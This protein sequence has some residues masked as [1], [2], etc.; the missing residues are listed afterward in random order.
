METHDKLKLGLKLLLLFM[1]TALIAA[2]I[3]FLG[4]SNIGK[5]NQVVA[6]M[7]ANNLV[8]ITFISEANT[9]VINHNRRVCIYVLLSERSEKAFFKKKMMESEENVKTAIN[10]FRGSKLSD[11]ERLLLTKFDRIWPV[12]LENVKKTLALSEAGKDR[13]AESLA[14]GE[15]RLKFQEADDILSGL[16]KQEKR[17]AQVA[18][19]NSSNIYHKNRIYTITLVLIC[20]AVSLLVGFIV[21]LVIVAADAPPEI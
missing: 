15:T 18:Y 10:M 12:Y 2:I 3:G 9:E 7:Y 21:S 14:I 16:V 17:Q 4:V 19:E 5:I 20:V 13:E 11:Q 8:P 1:S 6:E